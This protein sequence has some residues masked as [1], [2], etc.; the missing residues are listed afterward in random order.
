MLRVFSVMVGASLLV[1][2]ALAHSSKEG[3]MPEDGAV[4]EVAP[5]EI[6]I[7]FDEAAT[8]TRV[9]L[10]HSHGDVSDETRLDAPRDA[11][12]AA[13][14]EA[15]DLGPGTYTVDWRALSSDGHPVNG[16]FS[17]TVTGD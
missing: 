15:P 3:T 5:A 11:T 17:Y 14:L 12:D 8:L 10:T 2:T 7:L 6:S 13:T 9:A 4:L 16:S 1:S